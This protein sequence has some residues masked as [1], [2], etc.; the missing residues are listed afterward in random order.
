M[1]VKVRVQA[2]PLLKWN[3]LSLEIYQLLKALFSIVWRRVVHAWTL[4]SSVMFAL[5]LDSRLVQKTCE[6]RRSESRYFKGRSRYLS[7][8]SYNQ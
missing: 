5:T 7:A 8:I 2:I 3:S 6:D 4:D 1:N